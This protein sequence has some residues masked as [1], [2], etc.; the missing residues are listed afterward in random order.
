MNRRS[1]SVSPYSRLGLPVVAFVAAIVSVAGDALA[2]SASC[3]GVNNIS[4]TTASTTYNLN[5]ELTAG[6]SVTVT[7][8]DPGS[9]GTVTTE[10]RYN[11]TPNAGQTTSTYPTVYS[12]D[13]GVTGSYVL[14]I[15]NAGGTAFS[16]AFAC[17]DG[18]GASS[19][20]TGDV[21][22]LANTVRSAARSQTDVL[23]KNLD[24]RIDAAFQAAVGR[25]IDA[26]SPSERFAALAAFD[27]TA[28]GRAPKP[29]SRGMPLRELAMLGDFD[30][31]RMRLG[32]TDE[33]NRDPARGVDARGPTDLPRP[34]TL[35][36]HGS[37][38]SLDNDFTS[39]GSD[40]RYD[41]NAWGYSLGFDYRIRPR[42]VAGISAGYTRSEIDTYFN[43]GSYKEKSWNVGPYVIARP[44]DGLTLSA[45]AGGG[46]GDVDQTQS[47]A[48]GSSDSRMWFMALRGTYTAKP[49]KGR[50]LELTSRLALLAGRKKVEATTLSDGTAVAEDTANTRRVKPGLEAAYAFDAAGTKIQ[51]FVSADLVLDLIDEV[52]GDRTALN[53]GGGLRISAGDTGLSGSLSADR[54]VGRTD[55]KAWSV[56]GM[57]AYGFGLDGRN[58]GRIAPFLSS[59]MH[60]AGSQTFGGGVHFTDIGGW[61]DCEL[62]VTHVLFYTVDDD[63]DDRLTAGDT[64]GVLRFKFDL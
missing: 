48:S 58:G 53:L 42:L 60:A 15:T 54:Q 22:G 55:Y 44:V 50:P 38:V 32:G 61:L 39:D 47:G 17:G 40:N 12:F 49:M 5:M 21:S 45:V 63:D 2:I 6:Q 28:F 13:A 46:F 26:G 29:V 18:P 23:E 8:T 7:L 43:S 1:R 35:W 16:Y 19:S 62:D 56:S 10:F 41:G 27:A 3:A 33:R 4:G 59:D 20:S 25:D 30:T 34:F 14:Y 24:S 64:T 9:A 31:S 37:F 57:V 36:G 52:N 51:P 11:S